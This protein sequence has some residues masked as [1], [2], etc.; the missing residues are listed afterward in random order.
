MNMNE[1]YL[2]EFTSDGRAQKHIIVTLVTQY[3]VHIMHSYRSTEK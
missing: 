3:P 1:K 2:T